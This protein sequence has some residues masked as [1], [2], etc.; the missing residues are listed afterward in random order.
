MSG[1]DGN[2][3]FQVNSLDDSGATEDTRDQLLDFKQGADK[4]DLAKIN[5]DFEAL[6]HQALVFIG[7]AD[8]NPGDGQLRYQHLQSDNAAD[9]RT[10]VELNNSDGHAHMQIELH[11]LFTMTLDDFLL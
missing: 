10:L 7:L 9:D 6:G 8:F 1:G 3:C 4:I 2:D 5:A 11:G